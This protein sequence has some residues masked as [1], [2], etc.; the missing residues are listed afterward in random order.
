MEVEED[1]RSSNARG[2]DAVRVG[3]EYAFEHYIEREF[4][5]SKSSCGARG[6]EGLKTT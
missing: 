6:K 3:A 5:Q 1:N 4:R 2:T